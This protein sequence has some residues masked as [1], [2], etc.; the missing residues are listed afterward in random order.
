MTFERDIDPKTWRAEKTNLLARIAHLEEIVDH[1][2]GQQKK[3][4]KAY[5][6]LKQDH[7]SLQKQMQLISLGLALKE[8]G[9]SSNDLESNTGTKT[10]G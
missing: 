6:D 5:F 7:E 10:T 9:Q 4:Q 3:W 1:S 8:S 2:T